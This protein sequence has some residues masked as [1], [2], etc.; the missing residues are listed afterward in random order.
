MTAV[1]L[2]AVFFDTLG[3]L[4][5]SCSWETPLVRSALV[6]RVVGTGVPAGLP[7]GGD[8]PPSLSSALSCSDVVCQRNEHHRDAPWAF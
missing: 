5:A 4:I 7:C 8:C 1:K 3:V 2:L 6:R